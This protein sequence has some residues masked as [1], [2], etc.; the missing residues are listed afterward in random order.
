MAGHRQQ[1]VSLEDQHAEIK[2]LRSE[3]KRV[4][5][6]RD[7]QKRPSHASQKSPTEVCVYPGAST[8]DC[9]GQIAY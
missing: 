8:Q 6:E 1:D 4:T 2:Q 9:Q 3:L 5:E 7:I